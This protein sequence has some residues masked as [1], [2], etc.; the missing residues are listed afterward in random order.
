MATSHSTAQHTAITA[1]GFLPINEKLT[2]G[3]FPLWRAQVLS[4]IRGVEVFDF[5][6]PTAAP[7]AKYLVKKV[8]GDEDAEKEA[9]I[10]NKDYTSWIPKDQQVLSYLFVSCGREVL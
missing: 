10:L 2:R 9:P 1:L 5:L 8:E 6:S 7:P 4:S 3:N